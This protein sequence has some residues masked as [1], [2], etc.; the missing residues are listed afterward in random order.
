MKEITYGGGSFVT[1]DAIAE[2]LLEYGAALAN[3]DRAATVHVPTAGLS[4]DV[5]EVT[6]LVGPSSQIL[7]GPYDGGEADP[8]GTVFISDVDDK[9]KSLKNSFTNPGSDSFVDWDIGPRTG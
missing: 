9:I 5:T 7:V 6:V 4:G 8:D 2:A 3:A 1:S